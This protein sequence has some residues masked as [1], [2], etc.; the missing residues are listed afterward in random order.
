MVKSQPAETA[1]G[2]E[3]AT[4]NLTKDFGQEPQS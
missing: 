3:I 2:P 1:A 4:N